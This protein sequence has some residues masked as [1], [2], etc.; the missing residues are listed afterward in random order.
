MFFTLT[1]RKYVN[2]RLPSWSTF[3]RPETHN[4]QRQLWKPSKKEPLQ[5]EISWNWRW[6]LR[7]LGAV[8]EKSATPWRKCS[9][10]MLPSIEWCLVHTSPNSA[11]R[12]SFL[13]SWSE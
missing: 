9:P 6:R 7:E 8:S 13:R 11:R 5:M 1:T 10:D 3:A 4:E 2:N 12:A